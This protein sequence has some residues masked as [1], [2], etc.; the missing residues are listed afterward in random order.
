MRYSLETIFTFVLLGSTTASSG[1]LR[2]S[3]ITYPSNVGCGEV[4]VFYT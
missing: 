4:N 3:H 2:L 1:P